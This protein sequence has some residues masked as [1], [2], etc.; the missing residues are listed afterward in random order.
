MQHVVDEVNKELLP[1]KRITR[2]TI[3]KE[4]LEMTSTKKIKRHIVAKQYENL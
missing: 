1:Y 3:A 2:L 4:P